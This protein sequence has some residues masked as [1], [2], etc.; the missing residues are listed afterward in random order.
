MED[1]I[2]FF[3][4]LRSKR[5][6][7]RLIKTAKEKNVRNKYKR[8][9]EIFL[10]QKNI[11]L[12]PLQEPYQK[13]FERYFVLREDIK[14]EKEINFF[15]QLLKKINTSQFSDTRKFVKKRKRYGK[16][17]YVP[18]IQNL[19][20]LQPYEF[21]GSHSI[22]NDDERRYF[23][24]IQVYDPVLKRFKGIYEFLQPW[25]FRLIIKPNMITHY[26]PLD[27]DLKRE[28]AQID[29]F[30]D[31]YKNKSLMYKKII[32]KGYS[33]HRKPKL[34]HPFRKRKFFNNKN[35]ALK[36][37]EVLM[38]KEHQLSKRH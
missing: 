17:V 4:R 32:G 9:K 2:F 29:H 18:R 35:S 16:K 5:E 31:N 6:K 25:R 33:Y 12:V 23:A 37:A 36:I 19:K 20:Q 7:K 1:L 8:Q 15:T 10:E 27:I 28:E 22:L 26:K 38:N 14:N 13:G 3:T 21:S 24:C 11:Q 34:K 30:F